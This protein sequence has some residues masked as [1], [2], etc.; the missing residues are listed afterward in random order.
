MVLAMTDMEMEGGGNFP[1]GLYHRGPKAIRH[2]YSFMTEEN[3]DT[4]ID[5]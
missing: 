4:Y 2:W 1:R 5:S 3:Y